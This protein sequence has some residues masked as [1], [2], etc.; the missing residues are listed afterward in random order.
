VDILW[1]PPLQY[2]EFE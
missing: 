1:N 2:H